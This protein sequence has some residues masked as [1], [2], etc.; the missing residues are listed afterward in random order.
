MFDDVRPVVVVPH[1]RRC[2]LCHPERA[3]QRPR[4]IYVRR[5]GPLLRPNPSDVDPSVAARPLDD[6]PA[7]RAAWVTLQPLRGFWMTIQSLRAKRCAL[8][9]ARP[10]REPALTTGRTPPAT[11]RT[12]SG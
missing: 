10:S 9:D 4:R 6:K 5:A 2:D 8:S 7:L 3:A 12:G 11:A 1:A